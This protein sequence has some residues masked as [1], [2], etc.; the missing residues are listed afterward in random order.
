[1]GSSPYAKIGWG[2]DFGDPENTDEGFDWDAA[3]VDSYDFEE[4]VMPVLFG[5]TEAAP[6]LPE[7]WQQTMDG[8]ARRHWRETVRVPWEQRLDAAVPLTFESYGYE[9]AG[10]ALVLK[11]SL[12]KVEWGAEAIDPATLAGPGPDE[13]A[14]LGTVLDRLEYGGERTPRL[15]LMALY[16]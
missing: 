16:G 11:R 13:L 4:K 1:M 12:R 8:D 3:G 6:I 2:I 9:F 15:L 7:G 10:T 5:F 14:A